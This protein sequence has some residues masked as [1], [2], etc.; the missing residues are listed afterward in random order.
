MI[1]RVR[2]GQDVADVTMGC[3]VPVAVGVFVF[4]AMGVLVFVAAGVLVLVAVGVG[5]ATAQRT[6]L[7]LESIKLVATPNEKPGGEKRRC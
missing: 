2:L 6:E 4:V 5:G 3:S 1:G 7:G